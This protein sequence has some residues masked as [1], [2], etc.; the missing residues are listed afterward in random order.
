M[1]PLLDI[2]MVV[3]FVFATI[4]E[5]RLDSSAE[6]V[7]ALQ[8]EVSAQREA[9]RSARQDAEATER[10]RAATA[11]QLQQARD[12]VAAKPP[13]PPAVADAVREHDVL[14]KLLDHFTVFE[15]EVA[16]IRA[17]DGTIAN[18]CCFRRDPTQAKWESCGQVPPRSEDRGA[19][20]DGE[21]K[22]LLSALRRTKGGN[23]MIIV[24]QDTT[25][26][27]RIAHHLD[28]LLRERFADHHLYNEGAS[29][30]AAT[31]TGG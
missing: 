31:C 24:R 11:V 13:V 15:V 22:P 3:L 27:Y 1:L 12:E 20:L 4:Q 14:T 18:G 28:A 8:A 30:T 19:W 16:G 9:A 29:A 2:F 10:A 5:E 6:Q 7:Q 17:D 23:A 21:G 25:A 26:T